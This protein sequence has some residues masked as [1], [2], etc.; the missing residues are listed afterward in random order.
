MNFLWL[1]GVLEK[2]KRFSPIITDFHMDYLAQSILPI[3]EEKSRLIGYQ[4]QNKQ[5]IGSRG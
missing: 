3:R 2:M 5:Q 1:A 4:I